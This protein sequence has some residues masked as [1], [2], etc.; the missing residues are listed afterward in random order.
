MSGA[1][2]PLTGV[3]IIDL[4][5]DKQQFSVKYDPAKTKLDDILKAINATAESAKKMD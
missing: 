5:V 3:E 4:V 2:K 1:L